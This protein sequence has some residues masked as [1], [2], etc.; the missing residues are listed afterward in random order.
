MHL[1]V[2]TSERGISHYQE[3][4]PLSRGSPIIK[5]ISH[6][7]EDLPLSRGSP[8][9]KRISHYQE[10]LPVS[11][12]SPIIKRI[13]HYQEDLPVLRGSPSTQCITSE[14]KEGVRGLTRCTSRGSSIPFLVTMICWGCSSRGRERIKA[15][16]SSA[17]FHLACHEMGGVE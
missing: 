5:R 10:D 9:I 2:W 8:S 13:S 15:A 1:I 4:L 16:T 17:V 7:Q 11:R 6:Y 14:T 12:G 3:D